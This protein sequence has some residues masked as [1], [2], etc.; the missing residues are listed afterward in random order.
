MSRLLG[1]P[2]GTGPWN[3]PLLLMNDEM[4]SYKEKFNITE[5]HES[6]METKQQS[7]WE[8]KRKG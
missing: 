4:D 2:I 3:G 5:K 8:L 6:F 7:L 1:I